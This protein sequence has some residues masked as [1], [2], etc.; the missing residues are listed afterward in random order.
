MEEQHDVRFVHRPF[1]DCQLGRM[2]HIVLVTEGDQVRLAPRQRR[3]EVAAPAKPPFVAMQPH[4]KRGGPR[5]IRN[6]LPCTIDRTIVGDDE[7]VRQPLLSGDAPQL[8]AQE[9]FA[10][11]GR[12]RDTDRR[13]RAT[14]P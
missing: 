4:R 14:S 1:G 10:V 13:H 8:L 12:H 7:L 11:I 9:T 2:P 6:N 5:E 3:H